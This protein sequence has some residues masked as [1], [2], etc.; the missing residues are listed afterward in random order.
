MK[1]QLLCTFT[2]L[3]KL[4]L[5]LEHIHRV[6][7][8]EEVSN[9]RY[10]SYMETPDNVVCIYNVSHNGKRLRDTITINRKKET[11]TYYSIN[12]LNSLIYKL[13]NGVLDKSYK[14]DWPQYVDTLLL[15]DGEF[16]CR[17]IRI[18]EISI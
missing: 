14:I 9:M 13:N 5:C 6:Y 12:A 15:A 1:N 10:Y 4:S 16:N 7:A 2:Y 11:N 17:A 18:K 3:E 8:V